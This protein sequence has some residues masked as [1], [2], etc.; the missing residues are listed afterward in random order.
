V[1]VVNGYLD[2]GFK[3]HP[4][5][6]MLVATIRLHHLD[7]NMAVAATAQWHFRLFKWFQNAARVIKDLLVHQAH[8]ETLDQMAKMVV[9]AK[10][11]SQAKTVK[12]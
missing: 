10:T 5:V 2:N 7:H 11:V 8:Q 9:M 3:L 4:V 12:C 1:N 6:H